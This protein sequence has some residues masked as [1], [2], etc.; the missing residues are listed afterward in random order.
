MKIHNRKSQMYVFNKKK[1]LLYFESWVN[2]YGST[3]V[4]QKGQRPEQWRWRR[5]MLFIF[6]GEKKESRFC[7][8]LLMMVGPSNALTCVS[9]IF[10]N[11]TDRDAAE[12]FSRISNVHEEFFFALSVRYFGLSIWY[13]LRKILVFLSRFFSNHYSINTF[14]SLFGDYQWKIV[15][16]KS[17]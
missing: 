2:C 15:N 4:H 9:I 11:H 16:Y 17:K 3:L 14:S 13:F 10:S 6:M 8:V 12:I 5:L 7:F 1:M